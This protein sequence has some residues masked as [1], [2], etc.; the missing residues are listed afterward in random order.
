MNYFDIKTKKNIG[1]HYIT[2]TGMVVC[3]VADYM[4]STVEVENNDGNYIEFYYYNYF[5]EVTQFN[6]PDELAKHICEDNKNAIKCL[7]DMLIEFSGPEQDDVR[8]TFRIDGVA[9]D[10]KVQYESCRFYYYT[11]KITEV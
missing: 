8:F 10:I 11:R 6:T 5:D 3:V 4:L 9:W 7:K 2:N 1:K